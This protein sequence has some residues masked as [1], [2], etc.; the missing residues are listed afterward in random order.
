VVRINGQRG[1]SDTRLL[2][3]RLTRWVNGQ[4]AQRW[5]GIEIDYD[6]PSSQLENYAKFIAELR[7]ALPKEM[8]LSI[9]ALPTWIEGHGLRSVLTSADSS[10]LQVHSVLDPQ[11]GLFDARHAAA[12]IA[13]YAKITPKDFDVALPDYGSR[14]AWDAQGKLVGVLSEQSG[15]LTGPVQKEIEA[16]PRDVAALLAELRNAHP[17]NLKGIVWFRLPVDGDQRIW[18]FST[19][20]SVVQGKALEH[21]WTVSIER[22]TLNAYRINLSNAGNLDAQLPGA[23]RIPNCQAADGIG[24]AVDHHADDLRFARRTERVLRAKESIAVGWTR[25]ALTPE[26]VAIEN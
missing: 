7:R 14:V 16:D 10:V 25:C 2:I 24:Y 20:E 8:G 12:W 4:S 26:E 18:S 17:R 1:L 21:Q 5:S 22:D 15:V 23:L 13:T 9:T 11:H 19:L 6:C 3:E